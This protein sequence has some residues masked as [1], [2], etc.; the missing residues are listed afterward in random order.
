MDDEISRPTRRTAP[1]EVWARVREDYLAGRSAPDCCRVHG[2]GLTALRARAAREGWRRVDQAWVTPDRLDP[3]DEGVEL[4]LAVGGDLDKI[5]M[6]ELAYVAH[7]R[8]MRAVVRGDAAEAMRWRRVQQTMVQVD[9]ELEREAAHHAATHWHLRNQEPSSGAPA[10]DPTA[11][12]ASDGVSPSDA[13]R[14]A[15]A[16]PS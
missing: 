4:D 14:S 12:D 7:R 8:M 5:G 1:E 15:E 3:W 16:P 6:S 13:V 9:G 10:V 11:S 2:V